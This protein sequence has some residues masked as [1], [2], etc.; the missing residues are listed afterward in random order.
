M[1]APIL[2][3][4]RAPRRT[5]GRARLATLLAVLLLLLATLL[6]A[7]SPRPAVVPRHAARCSR[8]M[9]LLATLLA[10]L[11]LQAQHCSAAPCD[12]YAKGGTPCVAA[13]SMTR[14]LFASYAGPLCASSSAACLPP[15][16]PCAMRVQTGGVLRAARSPRRCAVP[17]QII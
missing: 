5:G 14:A 12:I 6:A 4:G 16:S 9:A 10:V 17:V 1:V 7:P 13:H 2:P 3:R 8:P 11:L 15:A